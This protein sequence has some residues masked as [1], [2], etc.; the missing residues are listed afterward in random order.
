MELANAVDQIRRSFV[1]DQN[2]H[3]TI[4]ELP[5]GVYRLRVSHQEFV[6]TE[7]VIEVRSEV[8]L[9]VSVALGLAPLESRIEVTGSATVDPERA[10]LAY[11]IGSISLNQQIPARDGSQHH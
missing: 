5:F 10:G 9:T 11:S 6:P 1:T 4:H 8:P 7:R 2:G 3:F